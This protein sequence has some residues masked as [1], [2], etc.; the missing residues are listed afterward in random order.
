MEEHLMKVIDGGA[1]EG[2]GDASTPLS[3]GCSAVAPFSA[4]LEDRNRT[5]PIPFCGNRFEFR[6]V[7]SNQNISMTMTAVN[8]TVAEGLTVIADKIEAGATPAEATAD[9]LK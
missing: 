8:T 5:A 4:R 7:G 3:A 2:Y 6:A 9:V 1:L